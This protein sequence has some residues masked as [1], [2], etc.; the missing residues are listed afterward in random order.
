MK[1][2]ESRIENDNESS[3]SAVFVPG[4]RVMY[5]GQRF[6]VAVNPGFRNL[7]LK[8]AS[9]GQV[10]LLANVDFERDLVIG[11]N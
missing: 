8:N 10:K 2:G 11:W 9:T 6:V 1:T 4:L 7:V 3:L 5:D